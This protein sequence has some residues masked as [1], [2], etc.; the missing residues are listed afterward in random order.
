MSCTSVGVMALELRSEQQS[1]VSPIVL[2]ALLI[3]CES[4]T[5]LVTEHVEE[6]FVSVLDLLNI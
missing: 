2:A 5:Q 6:T 1:V 3:I 4:L